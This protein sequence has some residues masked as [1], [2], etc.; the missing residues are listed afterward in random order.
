MKPEE[1][2]G[3]SVK[4]SCSELPAVGDEQPCGLLHNAAQLQLATLVGRNRR[5][6]NGGRLA[7][8]Q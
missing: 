7:G 2:F 1:P 5:E 8:L 3:G 6:Q 4:S